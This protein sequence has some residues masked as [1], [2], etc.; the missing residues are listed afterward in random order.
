MGIKVFRCFHNLTKTMEGWNVQFVTEG[1]QRSFFLCTG[2]S[3]HTTNVTI[4]HI[5]K[6]MKRLRYFSTIMKYN[7]FSN[8]TSI[9]TTIESFT[10]KCRNGCHEQWDLVHYKGLG[11]LKCPSTPRRD[12]ANVFYTDTGR[13]F[14]ADTHTVLLDGSSQHSML[15]QQWATSN[16]WN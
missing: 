13:S 9:L 2:T 14:C 16:A 15:L 8:E 10:R 7:K 3:Y 1:R 6:N 12:M 5:N 4:R 11:M